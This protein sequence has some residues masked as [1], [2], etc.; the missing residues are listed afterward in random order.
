MEESNVSAW[1]LSSDAETTTLDPGYIPDR[2]KLLQCNEQ[3]FD[4]YIQELFADLHP[5]RAFCEKILTQ[6]IPSMESHYEQLQKDSK[7]EFAQIREKLLHYQ[8]DIQT[9]FEMYNHLKQLSA[10]VD[11]TFSV[12]RSPVSVTTKDQTSTEGKIFLF[13]STYF[14]F[15]SKGTLKD[16][17]SITYPVSNNTAHSNST[18]AEEEK[19]QTSE[20]NE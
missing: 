14:G 11:T 3:D 19:I 15:H 13:L 5:L 2:L 20:Q 7:E 18:G 6:F 10:I 17:A 1:N 9:T 4:S 16:L 8:Q 12:P